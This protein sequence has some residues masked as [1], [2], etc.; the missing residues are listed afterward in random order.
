MDGHTAFYDHC[1]WLWQHEVSV[2]DITLSFFNGGYMKQT[3]QPHT[4]SIST[5][6][7]FKQIIRDTIMESIPDLKKWGGAI[8]EVGELTGV[9]LLEIIG[10]AVEESAEVA[11][12]TL[13]FLGEDSTVKLM[14]D[15]ERQQSRAM[16]QGKQISGMNNQKLAM[17]A[18]REIKRRAI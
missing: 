13:N 5:A 10:E 17:R 7:E 12:F 3:Q 16:K 4:R 2:A 18:Y 6:S 11:L 14:D 8:D 15:S 1:L 9:P